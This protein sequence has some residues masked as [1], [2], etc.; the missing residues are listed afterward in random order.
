MISGLGYLSGTYLNV[1][2]T[3]ISGFPGSGATANIII[4]GGA[5]SSVTLV[6]GGFNYDTTSVLGIDDSSVGSGGG[7]GFSI[8]VASIKGGIMLDFGSPSWTGGTGYSDGVYLCTAVATSPAGNIPSVPATVYVTV[9]AHDVFGVTIFAGGKGYNTGDTFTV[10]GLVPWGATQVAPTF[11]V[12]TVSGPVAA[13]TIV[14]PGLNYD[15]TSIL[16]ANNS[17]L[18]AAGSGFLI[19]VSSISTGVVSATVSNGGQGYNSGTYTNIPIVDIG[20]GQGALATIQVFS[21]SVGSVDITSYGNNQYASGT[22]LTTPNTNLGGSGSGFQFD[23]SYISSSWNA[24]S[25]I[26]MNYTTRTS[27]PTLV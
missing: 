23:I 14:T 12:G 8:S 11:N 15:T 26:S 6:N 24:P 7:S 25:K 17:N 2:L 5:V 1:P 19:P 18:G 13:C 3:N 4:T 10:S 22:I 20:Q 16:T 21:G 9:T 27:S